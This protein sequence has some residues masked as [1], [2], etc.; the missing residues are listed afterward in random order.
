MYSLNAQLII[1]KILALCSLRHKIGFQLTECS[2]LEDWSIIFDEDIIHTARKK[3]DWEAAF[4]M[5]KMN[6]E[7]QEGEMFQGGRSYFWILPQMLGA[8]RAANEIIDLTS[9]VSATD[10]LNAF[11]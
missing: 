6:L 3:Y 1:E 8:F 2:M 4:L 5:F 10:Q 11:S 9:H 7:L